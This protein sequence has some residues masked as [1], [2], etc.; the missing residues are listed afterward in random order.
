[1]LLPLS[2]SKERTEAQPK[3]RDYAANADGDHR[4]R[5][6]N[7][8]LEHRPMICTYNRRITRACSCRSLT[9]SAAAGYLS[10]LEGGGLAR[11]RS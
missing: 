3:L 4:T 2:G 5:G 6:T 8:S 7:P 9:G 10:S 11:L 1:M